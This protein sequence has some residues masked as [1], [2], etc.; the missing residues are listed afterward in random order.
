MIGS[1]RRRYHNFVKHSNINSSNSLTFDRCCGWFNDRC[2]P[3]YI[4]HNK[5]ILLYSIVGASKVG[6]I[7]FWSLSISNCGTTSTNVKRALFTFCF[8]ALPYSKAIRFI[9][10]SG[11]S[12]AAW[13]LKILSQ[14]Q[15][16]WNSGYSV[17]FN[18]RYT[19]SFVYECVCR[20]K[21]LLPAVSNY[22]MGHTL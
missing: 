13:N 4:K 17:S 6:C 7:V 2:V 9:F 8:C 16:G 18:K 10:F 15:L 22:Y 1:R 5:N 14:F 19:V 11:S 3:T 20:K 12:V 21:I